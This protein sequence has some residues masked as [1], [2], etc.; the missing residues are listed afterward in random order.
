[1]DRNEFCEFSAVAKCMYFAK[2][3]SR[4]H[5]SHIVNHCKKGDCNRALGTSQCSILAN[6]YSFKKYIY[7]P[8]VY[9]FFKFLPAL[10]L[11]IINGIFAFLDFNE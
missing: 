8:I 5:D 7:M 3:R 2:L 6:L 9:L 4:M 11:K 10:N 1:M